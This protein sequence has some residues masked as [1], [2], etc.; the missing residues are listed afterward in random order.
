M[1]YL[2]T[3]FE[4]VGDAPTRVYYL[5]VINNVTPTRNVKN[6]ILFYFQCDISRI[7]EYEIHLN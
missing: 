2:Q 5:Y 6:P 7:L 4:S 1:S 3:R